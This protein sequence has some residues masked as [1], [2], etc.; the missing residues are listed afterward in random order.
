MP[1]DP[2]SYSLARPAKTLSDRFDSESGVFVQQTS[3]ITF[4]VW[5]KQPENKWAVY[6]IKRY[7]D[8]PT[9]V[10]VWRLYDVRLY[11]YVD[12]KTPETFFKQNQIDLT[13]PDSQWEY[14]ITIN[15]APDF[16]GGFHGDEKLQEVLFMVD[17]KS[18]TMNTT[19]SCSRFEM[20]QHT[21]CYDPTNGTTK[22]GDMYVRHIFTSEGLQ[23]KFKFVWAAPFTV[24]ASYA[25][26]I[27]AKRG[28]GFTTKARYIEQATIQDISATGHAA[29]GANTYGVELW[30]DTTNASLGVEFDNVGWFNGFVKSGSSGMWIADVAQYNKAYPTRIIAPN[31]ETV[32]TGTVWELS[33]KYRILSRL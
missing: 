5:I 19:F 13:V 20:V 3:A 31:S 25:A 32:T 4:S 23:L 11:D 29:P 6:T 26:M 17:G 33:A 15:G 27:P 22:A 9:N 1:F 21:I 14:A 2:I 24:G 28:A 10:D 7:T 12:G 30:N 8:I 18:V 16:F